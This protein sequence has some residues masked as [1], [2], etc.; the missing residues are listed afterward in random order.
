[1][2][3]IY[4]SESSWPAED[5]RR[6]KRETF[7]QYAGAG[8][9][10]KA[11]AS[12]RKK[13]IHALSYSTDGKCIIFLSYTLIHAVHSDTLADVRD[14]TDID[15][16]HVSCL[17]VSPNEQHMALG[18][19]D[20]VIHILDVKL[21]SIVRGIHRGGDVIR[22]ITFSPD[23][24]R[25]AAS[26]A[27]NSTICVR[28]SQTGNTVKEFDSGLWSSRIRYSPDGTRI[29]TVSGIRGDIALWDTTSGEEIG[30]PWRRIR[31]P[32]LF[33]TFSADGTR[34]ISAS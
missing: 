1:M 33:V 9:L 21:Y 32:M 10:K 24:S 27:H 11:K 4:S 22:S 8:V 6:R 18:S 20:G 17:A 12:S 23:G 28:D 34:I 29:I 5:S 31:T 13:W 30:E 19:E 25:L 26:F 2:F 15:I 3:I 7:I 16:H 14:P